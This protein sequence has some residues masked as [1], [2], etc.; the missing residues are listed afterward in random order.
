MGCRVLDTV[1][2]IPSPTEA[3]DDG[4]SRARQSTNSFSP[5]ADLGGFRP[6]PLADKAFRTAGGVLVDNRKECINTTAVI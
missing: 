6:N 5:V 3:I 4:S 1:S 2:A